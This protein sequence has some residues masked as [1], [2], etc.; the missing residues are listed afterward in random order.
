M[1]SHDDKEAIRQS[2]TFDALFDDYAAV[3]D[4]RLFKEQALSDLQRSG[5]IIEV[6]GEDEDSLTIRQIDPHASQR[7]NVFRSSDDYQKWLQS[8]LY[9]PSDEEVLASIGKED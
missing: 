6:E 2:V 4:M 1:G 3:P 8:A 9:E 7:Y 5:K